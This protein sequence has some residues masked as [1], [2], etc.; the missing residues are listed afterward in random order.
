[1]NKLTIFYIR[2]F[3]MILYILY[4]YKKV[5]FIVIKVIVII[6]YI[7]CYIMIYRFSI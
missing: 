5:I 6:N 1:M 3:Y 2:D 4:I 7:L